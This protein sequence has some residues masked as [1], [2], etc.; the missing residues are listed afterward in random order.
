MSSKRQ[1]EVCIISDI[2]LGTYGSCAKE[3][4]HYL[5]SIDPGILVINGDWLDIWNF[6]SNYWPP[7]HTENLF[8][9][10]DFLRQGIPVYYISGNHD[11]MVRKMTD[12]KLDTLE[13]RDE[14]ILELDGKTH[15]IFHGD[16]FDLSVGSSA[17]WLAKLGGR[18]YDYL[19]RLNR[20]INMI[21]AQ[22]GKDKVMLSK[23]VKDGVKSM[24][25]SKVSDFEEIAIERAI[26]HGYDYVICGHIHRP[27][28]RHIK[29]PEGEVTYLNSG[30]WIENLTS[31][32]YNNGKWTLFHYQN[33]LAFKNINRGET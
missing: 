22:F 11:E 31:L 12:F 25:K 20:L 16:I 28:I 10:L 21:R 13:I 5:K 30:D 26:L 27:Q 9:V 14:L 24:V 23:M 6:S 3:L 18:S 8:I 17:K 2:H 29:T 15:W 7:E 19:I 1:V 32:E 4:N 33:E